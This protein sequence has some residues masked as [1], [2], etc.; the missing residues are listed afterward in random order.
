MTQ[1]LRHCS[2]ASPAVRWLPSVV[3]TATQ[4]FDLRSPG[5]LC[6]WPGGLETGTRY[7]TIFEIWRVL[8]TVFVVIWKL[9]FSCF[10]SVHSIGLLQAYYIILLVG[11]SISK[12]MHNRD[13]V[14][15]TTTPQNWLWTDN[16]MACPTVL[17][18]MTL[19]DLQGHLP[20]ACVFWNALYRTVMRPLTR[21]QL[22]L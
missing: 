20:I 5:L 18:P 17:F 7:Q 19:N 16:Y 3:R 15:P 11:F 2:S 21:F 1:H 8:L 4:A 14:R 9:F 13:V 12:M 6:G 10:N 22:T